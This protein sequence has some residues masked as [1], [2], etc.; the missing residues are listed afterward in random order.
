VEGAKVIM[1]YVVGFISDDGLLGRTF[2]VDS[3][4]AIKEAL[5]YIAKE[6]K[7]TELTEQDIDTLTYDY[8]NHATSFGIYFVGR[9]ENWEDYCRIDE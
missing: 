7:D 4:E 6:N 5:R 8:C 9:L 1:R 3:L 2:A